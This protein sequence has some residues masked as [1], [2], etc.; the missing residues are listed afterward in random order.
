MV[1]SSA[2]KLPIVTREWMWDKFATAFKNY[3]RV[4]HISYVWDK[5]KAPGA[6]PEQLA[7]VED[8]SELASLTTKTPLAARIGFQA[9]AVVRASACTQKHLTLW[10]EA[11]VARKKVYKDGE[12]LH[13]ESSH[14]RPYRSPN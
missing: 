3:L 2:V 5:N 11:R 4:Q 13:S 14:L 1:K 10:A 7:P 9:G 6:A 8:A 12:S